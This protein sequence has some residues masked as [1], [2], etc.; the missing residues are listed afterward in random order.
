MASVFIG[1]DPG[2][3]GGLAIISPSGILTSPMPETEKELWEWFNALPKYRGFGVYHACIEKVGAMPGQGV[4]SMFT[5][6]RGY[7]SVR[8]A[9]IASGI[10]FDEIL[11]QK[12][13]K[14][15]G[16]GGRKEAGGKAKFKKVLKARA[17]ELFP[18][19]KV[20][21]KNA[22]ALLLALYCQRVFGGKG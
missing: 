6:G 5:F 13:Q 17:Q 7:G 22:D 1:I 3:L 2:K 14:E 16:V 12:W 21:P 8:M 4:T 10:P 9:L 18:G 15:M 11:P 20:T 19:E